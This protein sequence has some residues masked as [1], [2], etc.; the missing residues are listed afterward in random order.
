[1]SDVQ[2]FIEFLKR[3]GAYDNFVSKMRPNY[4]E[5]CN[6][7]EPRTFVSSAFDW[8]AMGAYEYWSDIDSKW[9][10]TL[11]KTYA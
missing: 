4:L 6:N 8:A 5:Q 7:L 9:Q 2:K 10:Q 11:N 3:W 1:M